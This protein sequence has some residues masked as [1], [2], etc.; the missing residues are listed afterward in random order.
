MKNTEINM[1]TSFQIYCKLQKY[2]LEVMYNVLTIY[3][4]IRKSVLQLD[5]T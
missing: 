1:A 5:K 4:I 3:T 2:D